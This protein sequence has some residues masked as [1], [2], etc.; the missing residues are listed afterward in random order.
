MPQNVPSFVIYFL[1]TF[2][3]LAGAGIALTIAE[4]LLAFARPARVDEFI[5]SRLLFGMFAV[6]I[7]TIFV[8]SRVTRFGRQKDLWR[9]ALSGCPGWMRVSLYVTFGFA[10]INFLY[11]AVLNQGQKDGPTILFA[12]GHLLVFYGVAFAVMYSAIHK[13]E[14][15]STR[16]CAQGHV[17]SPTD[18][19]CPVCGEK[20]AKPEALDSL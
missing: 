17:V 12:G 7:P 19:F 5:V 4:Y 15:L 1:R 3:V 2:L 14:L 20:L 13:P 9:I 18:G 16:T 10:A 11:F 8:M 6:W